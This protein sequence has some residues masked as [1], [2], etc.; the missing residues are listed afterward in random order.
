M[1]P[2]KTFHYCVSTLPTYTCRPASVTYM[3]GIATG[4]YEWM[5]FLLTCDKKLSKSQLVLHMCQL[6]EDNRRTKTMHMT[7]NLKSFKQSKQ[8]EYNKQVVPT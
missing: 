7:S 6:K 8:L 5:M 1:S 2:G 3:R 4:S